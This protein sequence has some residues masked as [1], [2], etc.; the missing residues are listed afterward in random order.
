MESANCFGN[1][2]TK[3]W[4]VACDELI[5]H[6]GG[7]DILLVASYHERIFKPLLL[8]TTETGDKRRL[9]WLLA[10]PITIGDRLYL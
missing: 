8:H 2:L 9:D 10:R 4:E 3:C 6:P 1:N 7:I 5:S